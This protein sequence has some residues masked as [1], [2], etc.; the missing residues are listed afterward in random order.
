MVFKIIQHL[1]QIWSLS[2]HEQKFFIRWYFLFLLLP[3]KYFILF[4]KHCLSGEF[5]FENINPFWPFV[6]QHSLEQWAEWLNRVVEE[7]LQPHQGT[8]NFPKAARQFL[9]KWSF[10]SS[11][12]IR[13]LTLRSA[14]SFGSF[15]LIRL[16]YDE[17]MFYLVEHK[18]ADATGKSPLAV[19]AEVSPLNPITRLTFKSTIHFI[20][21]PW[22]HSRFW[23][24]H[25]KGIVITSDVFCSCWP[26]FM[27]NHQ[28]IYS[29]T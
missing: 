14:A 13:D 6:R 5:F 24:P 11:M 25:P 29:R 19:M 18:V 1:F 2:I 22:P 26:L 4:R 27:S 12:I 3:L 10:Y 16:L 9:L 20:I 15:H 23:A 8:E 17:Y 28:T 7:V 21:F